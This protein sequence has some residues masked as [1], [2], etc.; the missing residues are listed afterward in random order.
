MLKFCGVESKLRTL[1]W[2]V[3]FPPMTTSLG[4]MLR[5]SWRPLALVVFVLKDS[6]LVERVEVVRISPGVPVC[7]VV[8]G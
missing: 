6:M 5:T 7:E 4:S 8:V 3:T 2:T 1:T